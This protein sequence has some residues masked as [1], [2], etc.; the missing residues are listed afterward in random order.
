MSAPGNTPANVQ[1]FATET[2]IDPYEAYTTLR[3]QAPVHFVPEFGV[4][5]ITRYDLLRQATMD[6][7][8]YSSKFDGFLQ[9]SQRIAFAAATPEVQ[10]QLVGI[11]DEM[12]DVPPTMLT[13]DEPEHT[14]YRS[15]VNQLFTAAQ[16][17]KAE[18]SVQAV[19]DEAI[20]KFGS[21]GRIDFVESFATAVPR[22]SHRRCRRFASN[23]IARRRD[24]STRPTRARPAK[25]LRT[26][27]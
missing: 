6:T 8:T 13:L 3:D 19:I 25:A 15:L 26:I 23:A 10:A 17:R 27:G 14:Q 5:V 1:L 22:C 4:H 9:E 11:A 18:A 12:L 16:I 7:K 24:G 21:A 20:S 2:L